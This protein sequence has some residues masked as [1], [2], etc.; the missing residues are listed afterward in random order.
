M[1]HIGMPTSAESDIEEFAQ[2]YD[3]P[4][5]GEKY[6]PPL[7]YIWNDRFVRLNLTA[8]RL[9]YPNVKLDTCYVQFFQR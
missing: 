4:R 5:C 1:C 8:Y 2:T 3:D 7:T 9:Y 6:G